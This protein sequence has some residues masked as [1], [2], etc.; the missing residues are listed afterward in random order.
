MNIIVPLC[1][2]GERFVRQGFTT[3]KPLI[4]VHGKEILLHVLNSLTITDADQ[5]YIIINP[6]LAETNLESVVSKQY[7]RARFIMLEGETTGASETIH[8]ALPHIRNE[9]CLLV[10]GDNFYTTDIISELRKHADKNQIVCF[11]TVGEKPVFSYIE[12]DAETGTIVAIAEK[13]KISQFA[14]TGA[15]YFS[16]RA[17]LKQ[18]VASL[19]VMDQEPYISMAIA[20]TLKTTAWTPLQ[21]PADRYVSLGTPEQVAAYKQHTIGFLFDLDG[22]LVNTDA[23]YYSVWQEIL[24]EY[25]ITLTKDIYDMYIYSNNDANVKQNLLS[26]VQLTIDELSAKKDSLFLKHLEMITFIPGA[27]EFIQA[28]KQ[29]GHAIAVVTNSNRATAEAILNSMGIH[30]DLLVIGSECEAA[31]PAPHPYL[32]AAKLLDI[33]ITRCVVFEDSKTGVISARAANAQ[34]IVGISE[35]SGILQYAGADLIYPD[36]SFPV[37]NIMDYKRPLINYDTILYN[38]IK[39]RYANVTNINVSPIQLKGGFIADVFSVSM[40]LDGVPK[41]AIFKLMNENDSPL[42]KMAHFLDLYGRENYFYESIAQFVPVHVPQCYGLIRDSSFKTIGFLLEDLREFAVLNRNLST[43]PIDVSLSVISHMAKLHAGFW[44]KDLTRHFPYLRKHNDSSFKPSWNKFLSDRLDAFISKWHLILTPAHIELCRSIVG[45]FSEIQD[46]LSTPPL[47]L[48]H[49]D[50]K[51]PNMFYKGD[52]PY[53][54]DWQY[55][56]HGKGVQ[57]LVFFL[58]ESYSKERMVHLFPLFKSYYYQKLQEYG[59]TDYSYEQYS[60]DIKN[61]MFH[62]PF[63]VALWFGTTPNT[64]LIDVNFPYFFIQRLFAFYD[65]VA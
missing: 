8:R 30:A 59:V 7:P 2:K 25:N 1:G 10:D 19:N 55:I 9:A 54:I 18:A 28:R 45:R 62:F 34:C 29:E 53:F 16:S 17:L 57:D 4:Q 15:Y 58:I 38:S 22:T 47:T 32:E 6:R 42:N 50:I 36:F 12:L 52:I 21:I 40:E 48:T 65:L 20:T 49:G 60:A 37:A 41:K 3:A 33:P 44:N 64:D 26:G 5:L 61:A 63:F 39:S 23:A 46:A 13:K 11:E 56:A 51:S 14:N 43:E 27:A 35:S 31:K 24:T